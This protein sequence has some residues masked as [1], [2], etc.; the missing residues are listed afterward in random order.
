L[1]I[2][3]MVKRAEHVGAQTIRCYN[4]GVHEGCSLSL[5]TPTLALLRGLISRGQ[6]GLTYPYLCLDLERVLLTY[7][8][9]S[10]LAREQGAIAQ[11]RE[12]V[13]VMRLEMV[14]ISSSVPSLK[15]SPLPLAEYRVPDRSRR[16]THCLS[17]VVYHQAIFIRSDDAGV[18][19]HSPV[20][21]EQP[22][23][24]LPDP[25]AGT[26]VIVQDSFAP[27]V[28]FL[29]NKICFSARYCAN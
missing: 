15:Y 8:W 25:H 2:V 7:V 1:W 3:A 4:L 24:S 29:R 6:F 21:A 20:T 19:D 16:H 18:M 28:V 17:R 9:I 14:K 11:R 26:L 27:R 10:R 23:M 5:V 22:S 12:P 13:L